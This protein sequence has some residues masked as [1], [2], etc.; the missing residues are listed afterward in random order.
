[1]SLKIQFLVSEVVVKKPGMELCWITHG[2]TRTI[3]STSDDE[4][5]T[6][7]VLI[8]YSFNTLNIFSAEPCCNRCVAFVCRG[9]VCGES[10]RSVLLGTGSAV[11]AQLHFQ[12]QS[13][14]CRGEK[15]T[16]P[17]R[18]PQ[19][20]PTGR[21]PAQVSTN[22]HRALIWLYKGSSQLL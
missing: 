14:H 16:V 8:C 3:T 18:V 12:V 9:N 10:Y 19:R 5:T 11:A 1:M 15:K 21:H 22:T 17:S 13:H 20:L 6:T 4:S 2:F 7:N